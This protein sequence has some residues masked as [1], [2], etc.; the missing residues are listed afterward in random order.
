VDRIEHIASTLPQKGWTKPEIDKAVSILRHAPEKKSD[1]IKFLDQAMYWILLL[2]GILA[3]FIISI[4]LVPFLLV[5]TGPI[6]YGALFFLGVVFG[7]MLD[8][9]VRET[10]YLQKK[11]FVVAE[12]LIPA[13]ALINVYM[14]TNLSNKLAVVLQLQ[15][16]QQPWIVAVTYVVA[17]SLPHVAYKVLKKPS[18]HAAASVY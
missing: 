16:H 3:N 5:L 9:I 11:H 4:V 18:A 2:V 8:V 10:E 15:I 1:V 6:L 17:F 13:I 7:T 14:I 12:L